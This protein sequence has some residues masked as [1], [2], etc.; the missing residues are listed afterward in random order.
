MIRYASDIKTK[1]IRWLLKPLIMRGEAGLLG[2]A[3]RGK[4]KIP[5]HLAAV[6]TAG[7][8]FAPDSEPEKS[9]LGKVIYFVGGRSIERVVVPRLR[10]A[11]ASLEKVAVVG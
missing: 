5:S 9:A 11:G 1:G 8:E 10:L 2:G 3:T 4:E 6:V 7:K